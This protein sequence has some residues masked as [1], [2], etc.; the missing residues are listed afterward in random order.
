MKFFKSKFFIVCL[1]IALLLV[2]IP[3]VLSIFGYTGF[4]RN[5]IKT[6]AVPFE[7]CGAQV[8]GAVDGFVNV[9]TEYDN[10]KA[11]N[12]RLQD[13]LDK[14][15]E[16]KY[17]NSVLREENN[18]LKSY[19]DIKNQ[20]PKLRMTYATV[21]SRESGNY[22]TVLTVNKGTLH[23]LKRQMPVLTEEGVF[24]Y[25]SECGLDWAK[26][27]SIIETA[28]SVGV[29]TERAGVTG[30]VEGDS[31]LRQKGQCLMT[32]IPSNSDIKV[33]DRILTSGS[34]SVYPSGLL[35]GEVVHLSA[36]DSTRT[37]T[38]I[39]EPTVDL[40]DTDDITRLMIVTGYASAGGNG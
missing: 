40:S 25:I 1:I 15:E 38:A 4:I 5:A 34:G 24:G 2:L 3:S 27:V 9:F 32:Y 36:D 13:E 17:E 39:I 16:A 6:I 35:V 12:K 37:L 22:A 28:S 23:G 26:V 31:T 21:I 14:I 18:W 30:I 10:L 29:Y 7:W 19:L 11:E 20:S 33:G 8:S